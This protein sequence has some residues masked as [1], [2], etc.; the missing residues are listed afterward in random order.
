MEKVHKCKKDHPET[1]GSKAGDLNL[2]HNIHN[3]YA[4]VTSVANKS[5]PNDKNDPTLKVKRPE[6]RKE[7][8]DDK[9][10]M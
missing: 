8:T 10:T 2:A 4:Y 1:C 9:L 7:R 5:H 3:F 6:T